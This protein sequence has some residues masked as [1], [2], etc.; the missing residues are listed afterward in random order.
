MTPQELK[1]GRERYGYIPARVV[2]VNDGV[3]GDITWGPLKLK[4]DV[5]QNWQWDNPPMR[6]KYSSTALDDFH[7]TLL[8]S[9]NH[10]MIGA[11][12]MQKV[13]TRLLNRAAVAGR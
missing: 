6:S 9:E 3:A 12:V 10:E 8:N 5:P 7:Q 11:M 2:R 1:F 13:P 4:K